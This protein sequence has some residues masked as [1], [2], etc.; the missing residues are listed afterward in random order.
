MYIVAVALE[1]QPQQPLFQQNLLPGRK[2]FNG[3]HIFFAGFF[4]R[5]CRP[6]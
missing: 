6:S 2:F 3:K 4:P 1:K 5:V